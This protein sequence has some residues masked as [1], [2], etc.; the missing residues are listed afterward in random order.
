M[1]TVPRDCGLLD[2]L[3]GWVES[4]EER[5]ATRGIEVRFGRTDDDRPNQ[6]AYLN[7]RRGR[8]EADLVLWETGEAALALVE[9]VG[10]PS[11][12]TD[13][14]LAGVED[15]EAVLSRMLGLFHVTFGDAD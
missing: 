7:M 6:S 3:V 10:S 5:V 8:V 13:E 1:T 11:G 15:L 4:N 2:A 9:D 12:D 14:R